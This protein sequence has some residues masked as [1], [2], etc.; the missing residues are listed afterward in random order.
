MLKSGRHQEGNSAV[1]LYPVRK[2]Q[3][4]LHLL[5]LLISA[6]LKAELFFSHSDL[7]ARLWGSQ[8]VH[9]VRD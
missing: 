8:K 4:L 1:V 3:L 7:S 5:I 2:T 6:G 9:F